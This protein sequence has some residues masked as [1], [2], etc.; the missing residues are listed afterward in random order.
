MIKLGIIVTDVAT[1]LSG[2]LTHYQLETGG[3]KWYR[4]Q[5]RGLSPETCEPVAAHW[6]NEERIKDAAKLPAH[7]I[8]LPMQVLGTKVEDIASG[9]AG[10][11]I[12]LIV[13]I[14]GCVHVNIQPPGI[15]PK[16][17]AAIACCEFDIRR[18]KGKFVPVLDDKART[19][20]L[21]A[22]PSPV[23]TCG[24]KPAQVQSV[25]RR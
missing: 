1:G 8:E 21:T 15:V 10:T 22:R 2:M 24:P 14:N 17:G 3:N 20:S 6:L 5:P 4:F 9:F 7:Q 11:A 13:H 18:V 23:D 16:T 12:A 19:E 25:C